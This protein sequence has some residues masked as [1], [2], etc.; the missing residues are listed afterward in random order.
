MDIL[1]EKIQHV[2]NQ[3]LLKKGD[4]IFA[5]HQF[6]EE[7]RTGLIT[8]VTEE[9]IR[10]QYIPSI[11]NITNYF[12]IHQK[13]VLEKEWLIRVSNDLKTIFTTE[14]EEPI[15]KLNNKLPEKGEEA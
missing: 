4:L 12:L 5:K 1:Q 6:W 14:I 15:E 3:E 9:A 13:D 2:F 10:V 11:G 8:D 7:G